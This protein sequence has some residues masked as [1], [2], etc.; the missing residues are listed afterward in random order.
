MKKFILFF[1]SLTPIICLISLLILYEIGKNIAP[2]SQESTEISELSGFRLIVELL[3]FLVLI[4]CILGLSFWISDLISKTF[5]INK[6]YY[7]IFLLSLLFSN[8]VLRIHEHYY[9]EDIISWFL[10]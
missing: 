10:G 8:I 3:W 6:L 4:T 2:E 5:K 1:L 7:I 9:S